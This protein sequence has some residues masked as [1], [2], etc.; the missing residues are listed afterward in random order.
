MVLPPDLSLSYHAKWIPRISIFM[1]NMPRDSDGSCKSSC[2]LASVTI[3]H[4]FCHSLLEKLSQSV[5]LD[6]K[7]GEYTMLWTLGD[8]IH[9]GGHLWRLLTIEELY[10]IGKNLIDRQPQLSSQPASTADHVSEPSKTSS[11]VEHSSDSSSSHHLTRT[12]RESKWEFS[13]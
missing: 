11:P 4:Y 2:D 5:S 3:W 1:D 12:V 8:M 10:V 6:S 13:R 9:W 7:V